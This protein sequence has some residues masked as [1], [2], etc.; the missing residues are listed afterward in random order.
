MRAA[1]TRAQR[2][3]RRRTAQR[4]A[5]EQHAHE[6]TSDT[7]AGPGN[8]DRW[9]QL[10]E[11]FVLLFE[12]EGGGEG[13]YSLKTG[14]TTGI[15]DMHLLVRG[16]VACFP[17]IRQ[18]RCMIWQ[19]RP[20]I[21]QKRPIICDRL[22]TKATAGAYLLWL[23]KVHLMHLCCT[24]HASI[25]HTHLFRTV[26]GEAAAGASGDLSRN[27]IEAPPPPPPPPQEGGIGGRG[28]EPVIGHIVHPQE[29][30]M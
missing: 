12:I 27:G 30:P 13:I 7:R 20:I 9:K 23:Y 17:I 19:K 5:A 11:I 28:M 21:W 26:G 22:A 15:V 1:R 10:D 14:D 8:D 18:K 29:P 4:R 24:H 25:Q 2:Q 6:L 16:V 3:R